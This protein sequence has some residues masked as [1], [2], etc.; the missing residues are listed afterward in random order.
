MNNI[1]ILQQYLLVEQAK[2]F[3]VLC[4]FRNYLPFEHKKLCHFYA[5]E[6]LKLA[7]STTW[8]MRNFQIAS[9][10]QKAVLLVCAPVMFRMVVLTISELV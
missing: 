3:D 6:H 2:C 5:R 10:L 7:S 4:V 9:E 8:R 1:F